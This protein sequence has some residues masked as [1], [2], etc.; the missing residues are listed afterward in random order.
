MPAGG[1]S[2]SAGTFVQAISYPLAEAMTGL[3]PDSGAEGT[4]WEDYEGGLSL[5]LWDALNAADAGGS[6]YELVTAYDPDSELDAADTEFEDFDAAD[7]KS[8]V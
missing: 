3:N 5:N 6:P 2:P 4:A 1:T 8:V 7:R